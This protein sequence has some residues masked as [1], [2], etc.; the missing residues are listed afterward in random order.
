MNITWDDVYKWIE[1]SNPNR[2]ARVIVV[3]MESV[4]VYANC[5]MDEDNLN[6][7]RM[8]CLKYEFCTIRQ[9]ER[10]LEA[11]IRS[12]RKD[13]YH[14]L[15]DEMCFYNDEAERMIFRKSDKPVVKI[16]DNLYVFRGWIDRE[17]NKTKNEID[18][19]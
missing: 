11:Y 19:I 13:I 2:E 17:P 14:A 9:I 8:I 16:S 1:N 12:S 15:D 3:D 4:E 6:E 10:T 18:R 5:C 7:L